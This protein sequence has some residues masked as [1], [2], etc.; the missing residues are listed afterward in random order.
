MNKVFYGYVFSFLLG[1]S[2]RMG[3]LDNMTT[4]LKILR[5]LQGVVAHE[6]VADRSVNLRP[7]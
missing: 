7:V 6:V 1:T 5:N 2:V 4:M 3:F